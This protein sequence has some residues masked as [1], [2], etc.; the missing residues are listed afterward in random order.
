MCRAR[1]PGS[2]VPA[3]NEGVPGCFFSK[4]AEAAVYPP[5][6]F[7]SFTKE[8]QNRESGIGAG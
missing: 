7:G 2:I 4:E 3:H 6:G 1:F 5:L 8:G